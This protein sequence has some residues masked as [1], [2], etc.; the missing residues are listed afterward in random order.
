MRRHLRWMLPV[1]AALG[2]QVASADVY[3]ITKDNQGGALCSVANPCGTVT[4]TGTTTLHVAISLNSTDVIFGHGNGNGAFGFNANTTGVSYSNFSSS[5][6]S[7]DSGGQ[8][9]GWGNFPFSI[10][11]PDAASG[12]SSVSFDVTSTGTPFTGPSSIEL[13][14]TGGNGFT[15]FALHIGNAAGLTGFAGVSPAPSVPEPTSII[16]FGS[17]LGLVCRTYRRRTR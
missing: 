12:L 14:E 7:A 15:V 6:Y 17:I 2:T 10:K 13:G 11:G 1:L 4:V 5:L 16:L 8:F 9:G 3:N